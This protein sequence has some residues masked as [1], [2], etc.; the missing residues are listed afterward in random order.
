V[1]AVIGIPRLRGQGADADVAGLAASIAIAAAAA[2]SRVELVGKIG[3]DPAGDAVLL[4][5]SRRG[6]GNVATLRDP[7]HPTPAA[8][9]PGDD[10]DDGTP[11]AAPPAQAPELDAADV[12]LA[13][14]YLPELGVIVAAHIA[15]DVI[16]EAVSAAGWARTALIVV[17]PSGGASPDDLPPGALVL[18][19]D[20]T[21]ELGGVGA[22]IGRYAA[23]VDQ[24]R[25]ADAAYAEL[26]AAGE[27]IA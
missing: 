19:A 12:G 22:A 24:G 15:A 8:S 16:A 23:A 26:V 7:S 20:E 6:V 21:D 3:D 1:I 14:R 9:D 17:L 11:S 25:A 18:E 5:L 13:L 4:A 2:D 10:P 27:S